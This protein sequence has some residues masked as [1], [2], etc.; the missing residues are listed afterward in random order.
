MLAQLLEASNTPS[1]KSLSDSRSD[2][3]L[4]PCEADGLSPR[5]NWWGYA[6]ISLSKLKNLCQP[7]SAVISDVNNIR[8]FLK[9]S[10]G[11]LAFFLFDNTVILEDQMCIKHQPVILKNNITLSLQTWVLSLSVDC[12]IYHSSS[13]YYNVLM[14]FNCS[15]KDLQNQ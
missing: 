6:A 4:Q 13:L 1:E 2:G 5:R 12:L 11:I 10:I 15:L 7:H 9:V 8:S 3:E 14:S